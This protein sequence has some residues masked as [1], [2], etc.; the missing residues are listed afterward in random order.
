MS[1]TQPTI[2]DLL[3]RIERSIPQ[4]SG[5]STREADLSIRALDDN[6]LDCTSDPAHERVVVRYTKGLGQFDA[7]K[8]YITLDMKMYKLD[9]SRNGWHQGVWKALFRDASALLAVPPNPADPLDEPVG[10]V[11]DLDPLAQTKAIWDFGHGN[12]IYAI[13]P[14]LSHLVQLSDQSG[15]FSVACSQIITSGTGIFKGVHGLKQSLGAT[16][17]PPGADKV[18]FDPN[19]KLPP[20]PATTIDTFRVVW[21]GGVPSAFPEDF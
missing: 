14:A 10:P 7:R 12:A 20:F 2:I 1:A 6:L 17:T 19:V 13:G 21:P 15:N 11:E 8:Q 5:C 4:G 18:M 3:R 9:R 16:R